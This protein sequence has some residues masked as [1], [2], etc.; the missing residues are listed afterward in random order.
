[1]IET[2]SEETGYH[3]KRVALYSELLAQLV[4]LPE[5]EAEVIKQASPLHDIGK[6]GVPDSVLNK[7]GKLDAEE[8]EV[9]KTHAQLGHDIL[10][11][12][13]NRLLDIAA[14]IAVSHHE[15][16]N[17]SGYPKGLSGVDIPIVGRIVALA[18]VF[19][20]IGSWRCYKEP[21]P[22]DDILELL[23][24]ERA[25]HFDPTLIDLFFDNLD[26]FLAIRDQYRD[27]D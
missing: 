10:Q 27:E 21:W 1:M 19:D 8:W 15:K 25:E 11:G 18:D 7:P 14:E 23:K 22:L 5:D 26:Q 9:M 17:G 13:G 4:G 3:V 6:V 2:R 20:A 12:S 16:W 24:K